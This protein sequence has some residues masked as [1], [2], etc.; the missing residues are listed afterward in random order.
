M[1]QKGKGTV[2]I[3][4]ENNSIHLRFDIYN[5]DLKDLIVCR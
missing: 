2:A 5:T 1:L 4:L 3:K